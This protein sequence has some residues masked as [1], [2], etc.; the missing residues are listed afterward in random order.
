MKARS[1][2]EVKAKLS[3]YVAASRE[4]PVL[5][6]RNGK[7]AALL[8][9]VEEDADLEDVLL[10]ASPRFWAI[11]RRGE[12]QIRRGA[13]LGHEEFWRQVDERHDRKT[14]EQSPVPAARKRRR[15]GP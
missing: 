2:A 11:L 10:A 8:V 15:K 13:V 4:E 1:L 14:T 7:P 3:E 12:E 5:I 9:H 6:T